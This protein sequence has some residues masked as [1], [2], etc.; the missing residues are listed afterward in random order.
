LPSASSA[1]ARGSRAARLPTSLFSARRCAM[2]KIALSGR[3][4]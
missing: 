2:T 1:R 3:R 4:A